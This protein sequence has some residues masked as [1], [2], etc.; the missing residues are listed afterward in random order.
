MRLKLSLLAAAA[1]LGLGS[2]SASAQTLVPLLSFNDPIIGIDTDPPAPA[3]SSPASGNENVDKVIDN[4]PAT[5]YLNFGETGTGLIVTAGPSIVQS[6]TLTTAN[7][8]EARDPASYQ[9]FGTNSPVVS[10]NHSAGLDEPWTLISSG[11]LSLPSTR[12][13]LSS[14]VDIANS[15]SY[16]AYKLIFP[17]IKNAAATNSMQVAEVQFYSQ[18]A[19]SGTPI[20]S[21]G[22]PIVAIGELRPN[23]NYPVPNETPAKVLDYNP[24]TKYL[25]F[26]RDNSGFIVTPQ[27]GAT[28]AK[29]F[30][31]T[32]ANDSPDRDPA[33]YEIYG[34]N[35]AITETE[36]GR[37]TADE[38]TLIATGTITLPETRQTQGDVVLFDNDTAYTSY[39]VIFTDTRADTAN[40]M[41]IADFNLLGV[42]EP[43]TMGVLAIGAIGLLRRRQVR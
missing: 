8:A 3:S 21:P 30:Q 35:G 20:L 32:T 12:L 31:I 10:G 39:K 13:T 41:Q 40:S 36:N 23:S 34:R 11:D 43:G 6:M 9:L 5:K 7:D 14:P 38:W 4:N 1:V 42:P 22:M 37:G 29:G 28:T 18:P 33:T 2:A 17:T 19:A 26:G 25:N 24:G 27:I 16:G 15:T